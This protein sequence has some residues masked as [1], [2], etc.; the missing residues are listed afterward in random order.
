MDNTLIVSEKPGDPAYLARGASE[1]G[2]DVVV[3][4][5]G[6]GT[7][8]E[9]TNDPVAAKSDGKKVLLLGVI[10]AGRGN[11]FTGSMGIPENLA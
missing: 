6:D 1:K 11:D 7:S 4:A 9:I 8:N 2:Y 5:G 10:T 3:A